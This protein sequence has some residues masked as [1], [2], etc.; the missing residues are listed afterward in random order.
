MTKDWQDSA[1]ASGH[2]AAE[3]Q[4]C[5]WTVPWLRAHCACPL[6]ADRW[7]SQQAKG[8]RERISG[9]A[10]MVQ[11]ILFTLPIVL[12]LPPWRAKLSKLSLK[13]DFDVEIDDSR[14]AQGGQEKFN[15]QITGLHRIARTKGGTGGF[16]VGD[17]EQGVR[18][19]ESCVVSES[20]LCCQKKQHPDFLIGLS[21]YAEAGGVYW[22]A[23]KHQL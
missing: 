1:N 23:A 19:R 17:Q 15:T 18:I 5:Q 12:R 10:S 13:I 20:F 16:V 8:N 6:T 7:S 11:A 21:R 22:T 4:A 3:M 9:S 2:R 14:H